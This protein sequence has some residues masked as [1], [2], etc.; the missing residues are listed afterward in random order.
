MTETAKKKRLLPMQGP[1]DLYDVIGEH[2]P[3]SDAEVF[4]RRRRDGGGSEKNN[5]WE[6]F[7]VK[8]EGINTSLYVYKVE[9]GPRLRL[10]GKT[11]ETYDPDGVYLDDRSI[12]YTRTVTD[13]AR[14]WRKAK[15]GISLNI[16]DA[17][18]YPEAFV[19]PAELQV[20][21]EEESY[22]IVIGADGDVRVGCQVFPWEVINTF[23]KKNGWWK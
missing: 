8:T 21:R 10:E 2:D 11:V 18:A 6:E 20:M 5:P 1:A 23:A 22:D 15:K 13:L 17:E 14:R 4:M 12:E 7:D 19:K 9:T 16:S 3:D